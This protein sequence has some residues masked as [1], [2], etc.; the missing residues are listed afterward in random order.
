MLVCEWSG[1]SSGQ[2]HPGEVT[3]ELATWPPRPESGPAGGAENFG[4][5]V[6]LSK[7]KHIFSREVSGLTLA[8][9]LAAIVSVSPIEI[10]VDGE[11]S[12]TIYSPLACSYF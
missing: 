11:I 1:S 2:G 7:I 5:R 8:N 9:A 4:F 12:A 6:L 10:G 3:S